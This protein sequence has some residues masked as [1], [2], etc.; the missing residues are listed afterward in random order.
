M[1]AKNSLIIRLDQVAHRLGV[2]LAER[3][4]NR[5][6]L[7]LFYA[8][9]TWDMTPDGD[10]LLVKGIPYGCTTPSWTERR[11]VDEVVEVMEAMARRTSAEATG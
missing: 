5:R 9:S 7:R 10:K 6:I 2:E 1:T 4:M 8:N 3:G 11:S